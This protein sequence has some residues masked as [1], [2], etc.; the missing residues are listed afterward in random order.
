ML[1]ILSVFYIQLLIYFNNNGFF[2]Y[3]ILYLLQ[4]IFYSILYCVINIL[5]AH[6]EARIQFSMCKLYYIQ[7]SNRVKIV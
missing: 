5:Y 1:W 3:F 4:S 6:G 2:F 7:L